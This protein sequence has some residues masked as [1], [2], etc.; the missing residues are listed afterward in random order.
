MFHIFIFTLPFVRWQDKNR[1]SIATPE[2]QK[3]CSFHELHFQSELGVEDTI[4]NML[5]VPI[6]VAFVFGVVV[7][8]DNETMAVVGIF[9]LFN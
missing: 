9:F 4:M 8:D 6:L 3:G 1:L 5:A 7:C 2:Y